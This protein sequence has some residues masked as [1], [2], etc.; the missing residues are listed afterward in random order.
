MYRGEQDKELK[1]VLYARRS[2]KANRTE[3]DKGVPSIESQKTEVRELADRLGLIIV[4]EFTETVS[5]SEPNQRRPM[6]LY[7][8]KLIVYPATL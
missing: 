3:E 6:Q 4:K 7:V 2:I 5:A 1:Y 8:S